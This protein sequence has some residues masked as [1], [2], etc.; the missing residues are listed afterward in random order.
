MNISLAV[1]F[2]VDL[3]NS[4]QLRE[5]A[6]ERDKVKEKLRGRIKGRGGGE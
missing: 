6:K 2:C 1:K 5:R 4:E 3:T